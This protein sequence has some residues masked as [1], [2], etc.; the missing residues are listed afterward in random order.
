MKKSALSFLLSILLVSTQSIGQDQPLSKKTLQQL[1]DAEK[2]MINAIS[3]GDSVAFKKI[4][5]FDYIDINAT[6]TETTLQSMLTEIQNFKG[7]TVHFSE[8]FQRIYGNFVL[9]NGKA[10]FSLNGQILAEVFY[11]QGWVY[12]NKKWQFVHWQGTMTKDFS[13]KK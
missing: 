9:K 10:K 11:T 2:D 6:G 1:D 4:A 3:N 13:Q 8:Q 7:I 5:G 12:R